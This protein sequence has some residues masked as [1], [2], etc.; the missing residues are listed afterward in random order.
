MWI[1]AYIDPHIDVRRPS[2]RSWEPNEL[3]NR[4]FTFILKEQTGWPGVV[5]NTFQCGELLDPLS[6]KMMI[7]KEHELF[8]MSHRE[9][10][11]KP[12]DKIRLINDHKQEHTVRCYNG[13][14]LV[15]ENEEDYS[16][17][18]EHY[19]LVPPPKYADFLTAL[20]DV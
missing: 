19:E 7:F 18:E 6:E 14:I 4:K 15:L 5:Q 1:E 16:V 8:V 2:G 13:R 20:E 17:Y 9:Q 12:G 3:K 10:K 11:F